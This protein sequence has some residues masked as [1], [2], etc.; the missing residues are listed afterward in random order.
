MSYN[1]W[2]K[3][4]EKHEIR[5]EESKDPIDPCIYIRSKESDNN[6]IRVSGFKDDSVDLCVYANGTLE[7]DFLKDLLIEYLG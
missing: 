3:F 7:N 6:Y 5:F 2:I 4:L 1:D